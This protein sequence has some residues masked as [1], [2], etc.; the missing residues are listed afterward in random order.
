MRSTATPDFLRDSTVQLILSIAAILVPLGVL[1]HFYYIF[2]F[3]IESRNSPVAVILSKIVLVF[4]AIGLVFWVLFLPF[5]IA[6]GG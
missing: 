3:P 6:F 4:A 5:R 1:Y 2:I